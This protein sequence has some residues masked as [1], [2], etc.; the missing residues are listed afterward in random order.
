[1]ADSISYIDELE[2]P[3]Y[4]GLTILSSPKNVAL[5]DRHAYRRRVELNLEARRI[6]QEIQDYRFDG[7]FED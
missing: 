5:C 7:V 2:D 3:I 1:M 6:S 4:S